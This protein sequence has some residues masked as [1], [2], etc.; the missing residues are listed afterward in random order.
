MQRFC[1]LVPWL[2][3]RDMRNENK[4]M[5]YPQQLG[6]SWK[7]FGYLPRNSAEPHQPSAPEP[8]GTSSDICPGTLRNLSSFLHRNPP[9]LNLVLPLLPWLCPFWLGSL[10][11]RPCEITPCCARAPKLSGWRKKKTT[12]FLGAQWPGWLN[13]LYLISLYALRNLY[14]DKIF[15]LSISCTRNSCTVLGLYCNLGL[16]AT[17]NR[18]RKSSCQLF[19]GILVPIHQRTWASSCNERR[20]VLVV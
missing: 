13:F 11:A 3:K 9:E 15:S 1:L 12:D 18:P 10:W 19:F 16:L 14:T 7:V 4:L 17:K 5:R 20:A 6:R 2:Q 8:S